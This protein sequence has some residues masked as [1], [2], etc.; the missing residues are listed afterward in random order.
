MLRT[1]RNTQRNRELSK[2]KENSKALFLDELEDYSVL[3]DDFLNRKFDY[4]IKQICM[5][6]GIEFKKDFF[7]FERG[8][9]PRISEV[10]GFEEYIV[11]IKLLEYINEFKIVIDKNINVNYFINNVAHFLDLMMFHLGERKFI[12]KMSEHLEYWKEH[13]K[14]FSIDREGFIRKKREHDERRDS[15]IRKGFLR[16]LRDPGFVIP[17]SESKVD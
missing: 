8:L 6:N 14:G 1:P 15:E 16:R 10:A 9:R 12:D 17:R 11:L 5:F 2:R 13:G 7:Y 4:L 3:D